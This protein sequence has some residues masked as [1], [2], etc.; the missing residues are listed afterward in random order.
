MWT[1]TTAVRVGLHGQVE[2]EALR[3]LLGGC[4]ADGEPLEGLR[5]SRKVPGF[6]LA[7]RAPKSVSLLWAL[8]GNDVAAEVRDAH[9]TAVAAAFRHRASRDRDPLLHSHLLV[10]NAVHAGRRP[11]QR[12]SKPTTASCNTTNTS[13]TNASKT[14]STHDPTPPGLRQAWHTHGTAD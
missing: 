11:C 5:S 7:F 1:G 12:C 3:R 2:A 4:D 9:D 13:P 8:G 14:P 6:D 10:A